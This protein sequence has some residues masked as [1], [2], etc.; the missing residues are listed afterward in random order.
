MK[1]ASMSNNFV[2]NNL[3]YKRVTI[4]FIVIVFLLVFL[5]SCTLSGVSQKYTS[6]DL[7]NKTAEP[8]SYSLSEGKVASVYVNLT[9]AV[10][11][12]EIMVKNSSKQ[13]DNSVSMYVYRYEVDYASSLADEPLAKTVFYNVKDGQK[14]YFQFEDLEPGRYIFAVSATGEGLSISREAAIP[15]MENLAHFYY[16]TT[17][18]DVGAFSFSVVFRSSTVRNMNISDIFSTPDYSAFTSQ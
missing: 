17:R 15:E 18:I 11:G 8:I 7:Y 5:C 9:R 16:Q 6:Y 2:K 12:F 3:I 1:E 10:T 13:N 4:V 14:L